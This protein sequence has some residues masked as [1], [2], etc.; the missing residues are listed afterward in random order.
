MTDTSGHI[1]IH[2]PRNRF[3]SGTHREKRDL[4]FSRHAALDEAADVITEILDIFF[5]DIDHMTGGIALLAVLGKN[6]IKNILDMMRETFS[7]LNPTD[8][9]VTNIFLML[10]VR[11]LH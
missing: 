9:D 10:F 4:F 2:R 3:S 5:T 11:H 7:H 6:M 8:I 1:G